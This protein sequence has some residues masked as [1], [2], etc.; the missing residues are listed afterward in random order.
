MCNNIHDACIHAVAARRGI[1]G[2]TDGRRKD[3]RINGIRPFSFAFVQLEKET[4]MFSRAVVRRRDTHM[5]PDTWDYLARI[6]INYKYTCIYVCVY[7]AREDNIFR[8]GC[9]PYTAV[10]S[11]FIYMYTVFSSLTGIAQMA[12]RVRTRVPPLL[13]CTTCAFR[14]LFFVSIS[15]QYDCFKGF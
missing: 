3:S 9:G 4:E 2:R 12:Y 11:V 1:D 14:G 6:N 13:T 8:V 7:K 5:I 10:E 15:F